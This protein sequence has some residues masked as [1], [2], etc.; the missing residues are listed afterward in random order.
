VVAKYN[1]KNVG[2]NKAVTVTSHTL[3]GN[4]A[5]N[6]EVT[7]FSPVTANITAKQLTVSSFTASDKVYDGTTSA[8][9][10]NVTFVG[11]VGSDTVTLGGTAS[12]ADKN[13]GTD[14]TVTIA[15]PSLAGS[16]AANYTLSGGVGTAT[17]DITAKTLTPVYTA[18]N[19][20]FDGN[21]NAT[22][23]LASDDRVSGDILTINYGTATF[24]DSSIGTNKNVTISGISVTG[25]DAGNYTYSTSQVVQASITNNAPVVTA[26]S[27]T[28]PYL[29]TNA[30]TIIDGSIVV[31]DFESSYG[32]ANSDSSL[33]SLN[34]GWLKV[35]FAASID[36]GDFLWISEQGTG[37]GEIGLSG[38]DVTYGGTVIGTV[39]GNGSSELR[40]DL[41]ASANVVSLQAL[42]RRIAF[43][44][45][46]PSASTDT[47]TVQF[48]V[49]D[50]TT[51]SNIA[52]KGVFISAGNEAPVVTLSS[53]S[54]NYTE[55]TAAVSVDSGL[56]IVDP[57]QANFA[58]G[59]L[60]VSL[61]GSAQASDVLGI[62]SSST[63]GEINVSGT[64]VRIVTSSG[65]TEI[66]TI[67][68]GADGSA[69][70]VVISL[71]SEATLARTQLL[72]RA[73]TFSNTSNNPNVTPRGVTFTLNDG[74]SV[75]GTS[76]PV[77]KTVTVTPVNN[78]PTITLSGFAPTFTEPTGVT[79]DSSGPLASQALPVSA[80]VDS[81]VTVS[82]P[83]STN[84][85]GGSIR[86]SNPNNNNADR[87]G[88]RQT[89][90]I[91]L[92]SGTLS[93]G[94]YNAA[95]NANVLFGGIVIGTIA[96]SNASALQINFTAEATV[97]RVSELMQAITFRNTGDLPG[98]SR[99]VTFQVA[100]NFVITNAT[101]PTPVTKTITIVSTNDAPRMTGTTTS[102]ALVRNAASGTA[103][104]GTSP[105]AFVDPFDTLN[106]IPTTMNGGT[107][108]LAG[109]N[110]SV[111]YAL[112]VDGTSNN[113]TVAGSTISHSGTAFATFSGGS[114]S[115][116]VIVFNAEANA[117]RINALLRQLRIR[118]LTGSNNGNLTVTL[119]EAME[120]STS[121]AK[122]VTLT[123]AVTVSG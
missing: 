23:T 45:Y 44:N 16:D 77:T 17:A 119:D 102:L 33:A 6:Y 14:K 55:G 104:I 38:T 40:I 61:E 120:G 90:N 117:T 70:D 110:L 93:G 67:T 25:T 98:T 112:T 21:T 50:G 51:S 100:D 37:A 107:L 26:S 82:D 122:S 57:D 99:V 115:S 95:V 4:D 58:G 103:P 31:Q 11:L 113:I 80:L 39:S 63:V 96:T 94:N 83:D 56:T 48:Q 88:I 35:N 79:Q 2:T 74:D 72:A 20:P 76:V 66:G 101:N 121:V 84:F 68:S 97:E 9:V 10:S 71:N 18:S 29:L 7:A 91:S 60:T 53:G 65:F 34:G 85:S 5:G 89:T 118:A 105:S 111:G 46:D 87:F 106:N 43:E 114:G 62:A 78:V 13:V 123:R 12:F 86:V 49:N 30:P 24:A 108:T 28:T 109:P 116:L 1:N 15:S 36:A 64:S 3:T 8:T 69:N 59:Q 92:S 54:T 27:G 81:G 47:R 42:A 22:A 75:N 32:I 41:N 52:T 19:K 73:I